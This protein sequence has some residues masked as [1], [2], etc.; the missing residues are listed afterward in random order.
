[1]T[2]H[3]PDENTPEVISPDA[4]HTGSDETGWT[5]WLD[6]GEASVKLRAPTKSALEDLAIL[7]V[8]F[9]SVNH[10]TTK[11]LMVPLARACGIDVTEKNT[12]TEIK[13]AIS[14]N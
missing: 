4:L 2:H 8:R 5:I 6:N 13:S 3:F 14:E 11:G 12:V 10:W 7:V 1:M 9:M